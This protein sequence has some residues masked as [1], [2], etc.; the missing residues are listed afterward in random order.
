MGELLNLTWHDIDFVSGTITVREAKSG[1]GRRLPMSET[2]RRAL[3]TLRERVEQGPRVR[4]V[5]GNAE[6][7]SAPRGGFLMNLNRDWY[8]ALKGPDC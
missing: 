3:T 7:F 5:I 2:V 8:G 4:R 1:E 6:V